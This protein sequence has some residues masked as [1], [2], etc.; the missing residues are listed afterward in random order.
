MAFQACFCPWMTA[1]RERHGLTPIARDPPPLRPI[2]IAGKAQ[3]GAPRR[4]VSR[5]PWHRVSAWSVANQLTLG[6]VATDVKAHEI[7]AIAVLL[8][9][10]DREGAVV[11]ID[12]LGCENEI[13]A[14][15]SAEKGESL[16]AVKDNQ[17]HRARD[18]EPTFDT[19]WEHG[20]P[21]V[22]VT[23]SQTVEAGPGRQETRT[24]GV[25]TNPSGI[26][27]AGL[28]AQLTA[29]WM[30]ISE[31]VVNEVSSIEVRDSRGSIAA[32]AEEDLQGV[33]GH[34][35]IENSLHWVLDV[36]V[37]EDDQRHWAG[38]SAQNLAWVRK[39]ALCLLKAETT[40]KAQR[41]NRRRHL[42]GWKNDDLLKVL[43]QIPEES[44]A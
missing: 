10:W 18:L 30:V 5:S 19:V 21:G 16:L 26:R 24:G 28:W 36:C 4:T 34:W 37:R 14:A 15:I 33:R 39:R 38:N 23:A 44:G 32:T 35:G 3:R 2:A 17:P 25:I 13:A 29:I 11:T 1:L 9:L 42:A 41:I 22:D 40:S 7:T 31:R 6:Q 20:E 27:D 8:K 12:A 43:A